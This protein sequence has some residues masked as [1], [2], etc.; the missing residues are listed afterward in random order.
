MPGTQGLLTPGCG[1]PAPR[2]VA[3]AI[4]ILSLAAAGWAGVILGHQP[5]MRW[6][7]EPTQ[8]VEATGPH[9]LHLGTTI[10]KASHRLWA[11]GSGAYGGRSLPAGP[12]MLSAQRCLQVQLAF[13]WNRTPGRV[14]QD[15]SSH[16]PTHRVLG[17]LFTVVRSLSCVQLFVTPW[18]AARQAS[19]TFTISQ[20]LLELMSVEL[21]MPSNHLILCHP[22]LLL[23]SI[24]PRIRVFSSEL[25]LCIQWPKY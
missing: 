18:T 23:P 10:P 3:G 9:S 2:A 16:L 7:D 25:A 14:R 24:L 19:L 20:S 8:A 5:G 22:L 21:M 12:V 11:F 15:T 13:L 4:Q 1:T 17:H 6:E